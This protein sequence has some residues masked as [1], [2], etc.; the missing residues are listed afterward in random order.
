MTIGDRGMGNLWDTV[1]RKFHGSIALEFYKVVTGGWQ[2]QNAY[3]YLKTD[4]KK[5]VYKLCLC[6][7]NDEIIQ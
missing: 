7:K 1:E 6:D 2:A 5:P 4:T 3:N